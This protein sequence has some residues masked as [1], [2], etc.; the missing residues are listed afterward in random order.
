MKANLVSDPIYVSINSALTI[1][2]H[3]HVLTDQLQKG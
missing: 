1:A 3:L 2:L